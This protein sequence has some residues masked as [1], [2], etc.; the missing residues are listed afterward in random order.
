MGRDRGAGAADVLDQ[1]D[2]CVRHLVFA[3]ALAELQ[4]C[5][6]ELVAAA[7]ADGM[8]A[9]FEAAERRER[10][11]AAKPDA[12]FVRPVEPR[13]WSRKAGG[14]ERQRSHDRVRVMR[15]EQVDVGVSDAGLAECALRRALDGGELQHIRAAR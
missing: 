2:A 3:G 5:F 10:Q 11:V 9:R 6:D 12:I 1:R 8:A 15:L 13:A 14:F 7:G 4:E